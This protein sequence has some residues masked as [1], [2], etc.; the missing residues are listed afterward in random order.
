MRLGGCFLVLSGVMIALSS[1]AQA[2]LL[3]GVARA[4]ITPLEANIPTQLGGYGERAG[5]PAEG[6]H[7]TLYAKAAVFDMDGRRAAVVTL[8]VCHLPKALVEESLKK[9]QIPGLSFENVMMVSSHS[10]AGLEGMSMDPRNVAG[11]PHIGIYKPEILAFVSD[12]V[13]GA[14]KEAGGKL[15]PVTVGA[16]SVALPGYNHNRRHEGDPTDEDMTIARFNTQDGKPL[17]ALVNYTAHGTIMTAEIMHVSGGWSGVMQRT[18]E[19]LLGDG[20]TCMYTNGPEG[21]VAP[22]NYQGGSRW[23]MAERYGKH[24]GNAATNLARAIGTRP[25]QQFAI[26]SKW[27][28]LPQRQAAPDFMKIAG[29]EYQVSA[30]Q[31]DQLLNTMFPSECPLLAL[32]IND[33]AMLSFPGEPITA[34]GLPVKDALRAQGIHYPAIAALTN[35]LIGYILTED[36]YAKSG[37]EVTASFYGPKLGELML[38]NALDLVK[39][40]MTKR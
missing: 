5:K 34:I 13:S 33:F 31:L 40:V 39:E 19:E 15:Q 24:I 36:E 7:D 9:A 17:I 16:G 2:G 11:N 35:D 21:D 8:D 12:R 23:E 29:D 27:V 6:V 28:T 4:S 38:G 37:Y 26:Q 22:E 32:R 14:L 1:S 18:V 10:H 3:A 25:V 30:E 20:V